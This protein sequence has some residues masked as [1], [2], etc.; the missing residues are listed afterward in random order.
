LIPAVSEEPVAVADFVAVAVPVAPSVAT[1]VWVDWESAVAD[2]SELALALALAV[3]EASADCVDIALA[4][5]SAVAVAV[6][7][8]DADCFEVT[9]ALEVCEAVAV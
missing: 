2:F 5:A 6:A 8:S 4:V 1:A 3:C 9:V 7:V